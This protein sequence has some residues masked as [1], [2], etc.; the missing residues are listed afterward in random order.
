[1]HRRDLAV[2]HRVQLQPGETQPI[3]EFGDIGELA[4]QAVERLDDHD[5]EQA[6]IEIRKQLL[7]SGPELAGAAQGGVFVGREKAPALT[8][9]IALTDL[10]LIL[11]RGF[12]LQLGAVTGVD[13]GPGLDRLPGWG[14]KLPA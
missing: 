8:L 11:D 12:A 7:K 13:D 2:V 14:H 9:N 5:V 3:V 10:D 4:A 1:M 6:S